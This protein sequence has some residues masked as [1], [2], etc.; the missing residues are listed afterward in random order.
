MDLG[1]QR[2]VVACLGQRL[3]GQ[4]DRA[5]RIHRDPGKA[6]ERLGPLTPR[7][8]RPHKLVENCS[9]TLAVACLE[10]VVGREQPAPHA[11]GVVVRR[12]ERDGT[13][14]EAGRSLGGPARR[15][16]GAGL[17]ERERHGGVRPLAAERPVED[18][19]LGILDDLR[20]L[21]VHDAAAVPGRPRRTPSIPTADG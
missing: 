11:V 7:R 8:E 9:G 13:S 1:P 21:A 18:A 3:L 10:Q 2:G 6:L 17:L 4:L 12:R 15:G 19:L 5:H 16:S 14:G 20:E